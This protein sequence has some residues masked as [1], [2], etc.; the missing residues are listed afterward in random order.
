MFR[1]I[2]IPVPPEEAAVPARVVLNIVGLMMVVLPLGP[3]MII[4]V[5]IEVVVVVE[6]IVVDVVVEPPTSAN[7]PE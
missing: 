5:A 2:G 1:D 7:S 6:D 3:A 4:A